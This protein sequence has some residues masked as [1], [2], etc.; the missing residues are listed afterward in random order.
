MDDIKIFQSDV[1]N[2]R[3]LLARLCDGCPAWILF[4]MCQNPVKKEKL[5]VVVRFSATNDI[6]IAKKFFYPVS[7][8]NWSSLHGPPVD[9]G[10]A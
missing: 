8:L 4:V 10:V 5:S 2:C 9:V 1:L 7:F 6:V 3:F